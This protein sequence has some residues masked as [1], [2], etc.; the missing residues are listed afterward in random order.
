M[1]GRYVSFAA[2][3]AL[4]AP[5]AP[6]PADPNNPPADE[7]D[8]KLFA[9]AGHA[10]GYL[11]EE[12]P[13]LAKALAA[14]PSNPHNVL[15]LGEF[16]RLN[17]LDANGLNAG[18]PADELGGVASQFPGQTFA[19][20]DAYKQ[21]IADAK[22]PPADRA[23]ALYRAINCYAPSGNNECDGKTVPQSE[24]ARWFHL[25]KG[26]YPKSEWATALKYYW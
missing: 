17:N 1:R 19:R 25:L 26:D 5:Q 8:F 4:T 20:L 21:L 9:W 16:A 11:C 15:C 24:R 7:P 6:P 10:Q 23:Y 13:K 14:A 22:T 2:D 3:A 18:A 12:L